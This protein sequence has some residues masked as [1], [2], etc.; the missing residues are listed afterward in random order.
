MNFEQEI[1]IIVTD[2]QTAFLRATP[3]ETTKKFPP[4][5]VKLISPMEG[6]EVSL[7]SYRE[8]SASMLSETSS[9]TGD[10]SN[11]ARLTQ[12][13]ISKY[14]MEGM[15]CGSLVKGGTKHK[16]EGYHTFK[17]KYVKK[18]VTKNNFSKGQKMCFLVKCS[19]AALMK[20]TLYGVYVHLCQDT[21]EVLY[22]KCSCTAG[23]CSRCKHCAA[24]L[25]QLSEYIQL[26]L[27]C[28]PDD[29][30]CT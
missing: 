16:S 9:W 4:P 12:E 27:K 24:L 7:R 30:T 15:V 26:D 20:K 29:K 23:T 8:K 3:E 10:L 5:K 14:F 13:L 6:I 2:K 18:V 25:Y 11:M 17:E 28:D 1:E 21:G 19:V 22:G